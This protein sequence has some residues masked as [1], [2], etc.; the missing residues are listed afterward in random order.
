MLPQETYFMSVRALGDAIRESRLSPVELTEGFLERCRTIGARLNAFVTLTPD[1]ALRQ[2]RQAEAEIKAGKYR[3]PLHGVP[4]AVKDLVTVKGYP[5]TWGA[6]PYAQQ[7][8][9]YNAT[10]INRL[11]DAGAI[12][13]GKAAMIELAGG[14]GYSSGEASLT[15]PARNPWNPE[16]WTCGSS[17]GSGAVVAAGLSPWALGSDTRGSILCP[18]SWCGVSG[19]RPSFG[20][21]SRYGSMAIAYSMDK[22][23]PMAH[24]AEDCALVLSV[25]AGHD[26]LDHDS[27]SSS[28]PAFA[29][30]ETEPKQDGPLRIGRL[31]NVYEKSDSGAEKAVDNACEAFEKAGAT[32]ESCEFPDGPFEEA[33]ELT[34]L[35]EAASAFEHLIHSGKCKDLTDPLGKINGYASEQFS[36]TDYL[37][38][39]RV[40]PMLQRT[41]DAMFDRYSVL[42][43][44]A[45]PTA[46]QP[47]R[48]QDL[49]D[50]ND[51][52]NA[53]SKK[54][55]HMDRRA[56]DGVS[57]LCGLPAISVPCGFSEKRLP[58]G[59][60]IM[61]RALNDAVVLRAAR[62]YQTHTDWHLQHP[63]L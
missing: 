25:L 36:V 56:P 15:G 49:D 46:A 42:I 58:Y 16:C 48:A 38:V 27:I 4:Y 24:S 12:L 47:L 13:L 7:S 50:P 52:A 29:Y 14:L 22:L 41:A 43:S 32:V 5:T 63:A 40:R 17:S 62:L 8:F 10:V 35:M 45:E 44:P 2:A 59:M 34:I 20:R 55:F 6:V 51:P 28:S 23:G 61:G 19:L 26:P 11:N 60:Q 39:Q 31:T 1:L 53:K 3:G 18:S 9:D 37:H 33:A 30:Q 54:K 57:S 21:V